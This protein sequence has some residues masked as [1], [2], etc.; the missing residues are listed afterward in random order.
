MPRRAKVV[1]REIMPDAR[2]QSKMVSMFVNVNELPARDN[3]VPPLAPM[4]NPFA[5]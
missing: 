2:Y 4:A 3:G 5:P 1:K